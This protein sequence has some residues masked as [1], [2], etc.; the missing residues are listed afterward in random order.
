MDFVSKAAPDGYTFVV[1][2]DSVSLQPVLRKNV[3]WSVERDFVPVIMFGTQPIVVATY[4]ASPYKSIQDLVAAA[5]AKPGSI[6]YATSG[7]GSIQHLA[8]EL[9]GE[10]AGIDLLHVPYKGG[11]QAIS[12]LVGGQV[13]VA[14]LGMAAVLPHVKSG[15]ARILAVTTRTRSKAVPDAPTLDESV[16]PGYDVRQWA[17]LMAPAKTPPEILS[18][19]TEEAG[20]A[21]AAPV[22]RERF[23]N[24]GFEV[25]GMSGAEFQGYLRSDRARWSKIIVDRKLQLD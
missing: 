1:A 24:L 17:G 19:F 18:R 16:A 15:R 20:K 11:G 22:T 14:I 4:A 21:L 12:D 6:G 13:P 5:K 3:R 2:S 10:M 23:D 9:F 7:Q 8:G 25:S